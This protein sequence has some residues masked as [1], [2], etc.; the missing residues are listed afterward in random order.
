[1]RSQT[2]EE[3]SLQRR[4]AHTQTMTFEE[5]D[6]CAFGGGQDRTGKNKQTNVHIG[7]LHITE[8]QA[9]IFDA[10]CKPNSRT[11]FGTHAQ[12]KT[13]QDEGIKRKAYEFA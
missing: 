13:S 12:R 1:M 9:D 5:I 10:S 4:T 11:C 3:S 7:R 6:E 2:G 8:L